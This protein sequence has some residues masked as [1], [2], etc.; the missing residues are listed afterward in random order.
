MKTFTRRDFGWTLGKGIT[1]TALLGSTSL[2]CG[3]SAK[4]ENKKLGVALVGLGSYSTYQLAPSLQDTEHCY[5]AGIVTGTKEKE[6]VWQDKYGIPK[7]NTYNY[8]N[9]D[10]IANNEDIDIVYVVL[11]NS[12][13]ADFSIRAAK[14]GKH[15]I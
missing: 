9:F 3:Q 8:D 14:A 11:P 6:Q 12:M 13:H 1:A 5:L 2:A 7:E 10:T 4:N 15:V